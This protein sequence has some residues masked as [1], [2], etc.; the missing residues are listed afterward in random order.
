MFFSDDVRSEGDRE[1]HRC[2]ALV[3]GV[4][5]T[6]IASLDFELNCRVNRKARHEIDILHLELKECGDERLD[7]A[8]SELQNVSR[9]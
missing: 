2:A 8:M 7:K 3:R 6:V 4:L 5:T 1:R 9:S